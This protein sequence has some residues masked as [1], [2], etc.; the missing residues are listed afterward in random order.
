MKH[1]EKIVC[2]NFVD[3]EKESFHNLNRGLIEKLEEKK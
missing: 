3:I 2:G 1:G